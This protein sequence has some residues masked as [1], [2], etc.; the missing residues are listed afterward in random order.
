[1]SVLTLAWLKDIKKSVPF[2]VKLNG[3]EIGIIQSGQQM[4]FDVGNGV[5]NLNLVP[6]A[7]KWAGWKAVYIQAAPNNSN[8]PFI[9]LSV[10]YNSPLSVVGFLSNSQLHVNSINGVNILREEQYKEV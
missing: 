9:E 5:F 2:Y 10:I 1:M 6:K 8:N 3:N 7:S 4:Q